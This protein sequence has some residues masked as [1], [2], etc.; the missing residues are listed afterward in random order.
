MLIFSMGEHRDKRR[1]RE[2]ACRKA[3]FVPNWTIF[4]AASG[5]Q[6]FFH[7]GDKTSTW[8]APPAGAVVRVATQT[9]Q[10]QHEALDD[11]WQRRRAEKTVAKRRRIGE[12][13]VKRPYGVLNGEYYYNDIFGLAQ[14]EAPR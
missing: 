12:A 7:E 8:E 13:W 4:M 5:V 14:K 6:F 2:D 3:A 9:E 10:A 11:N 1:A